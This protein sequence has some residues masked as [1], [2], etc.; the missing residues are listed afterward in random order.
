MAITWLTGRR[1]VARALHAGQKPVED[2]IVEYGNSTEPPKGTVVFLT[3][4]PTGVPFVENHRWL[5]PLIAAE[6][7]VLL[8]I[9]PEPIPYVAAANRVT[10]ERTTSRFVRVRAIFGYMERPTLA[11]I[12][13]QCEIES[14]DLEKPETSFVYANPL[15]VRAQQDALPRWQRA[16]FAWLQRNSRSLATELEIPANRRVELSVEAAV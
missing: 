3:G 5:G 13:K 7:L 11:P 9:A 14:L 12:L 10:I 1:A 2:F 16:L 15:I 8:T 4:D 6:R